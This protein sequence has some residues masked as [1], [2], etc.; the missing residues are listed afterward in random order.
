MGVFDDKR[1]EELDWLSKAVEPIESYLATVLSELP[2][3]VDLDFNAL[4]AC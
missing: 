2:D 4:V 3:E 1:Y